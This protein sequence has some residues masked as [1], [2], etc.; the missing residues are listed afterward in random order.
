M[1]KTD[2]TQFMVDCDPKELRDAL[3]AIVKVPSTKKD[4]AHL[5]LI[6]FK[7]EE[8]GDLFIFAANRTMQAQAQITP[9]AVIMPGE[10][11]ISVRAAK[12]W[13][14][15]IDVPE[16]DGHIEMTLSIAANGPTASLIESTGTRDEDHIIQDANLAV[17]DTAPEVLDII[18]GVSPVNLDFTS[19]F[20]LPFDAAALIAAAGKAVAAP[21]IISRMHQG[22]KAFAVIAGKACTFKASILAWPAAGRFDALTGEFIED[23]A[24]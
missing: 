8:G 12:A 13:I 2:D 18:A 9:T 20:L 21:A 24:A 16:D 3:R 10:C 1:I 19:P 22:R 15:W 4:D 7:A 5:N 23:D 6:R 11:A 17:P 14:Q